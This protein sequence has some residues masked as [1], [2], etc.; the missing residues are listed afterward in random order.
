MRG[1]GFV[2]KIRK[3]KVST[4]KYVKIIAN[5]IILSNF[6]LGYLIDF[7]GKEPTTIGVKML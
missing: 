5:K 3:K 4:K 6:N 7:K 1:G 2:Y